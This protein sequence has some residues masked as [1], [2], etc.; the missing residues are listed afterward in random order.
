MQVKRI[1][2]NNYNNQ[3][4]FGMKY[5][6]PR[7]WNETVLKSLQNSS[8]AKEIDAKYPNAKAWWSTQRISHSKKCCAISLLIQ[9]ADNTAPVQIF[10]NHR[11][12]DKVYGGLTFRCCKIIR[13][14]RL[15]DLEK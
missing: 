15:A 8:L 1:Q 7:G 2:S 9:L 12:L 4:T 6:N 3:P 11:G 14:T 5:I 10:R 13:N